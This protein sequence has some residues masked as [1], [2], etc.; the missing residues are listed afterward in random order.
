MR[1]NTPLPR[2]LREGLSEAEDL[3]EKYGRPEEALEILEKLNK[4]YPRH[5]DVLG[6][7]AN[8]YV[9]L[10]N[11]SGYLS[12]MY[13]LHKITPNRAVVKLG[14]AGAYMSTGKVALAYQTFNEYLKKW[15]HHEKVKD[16]EKAVGI[17]KESLDD[18]LSRFDLDFDK[19]LKFASQHELLQVFMELGEYRQ[20]RQIG[21][22]L[23]KER[24][25]FVPTYNNLSQI[26]WLEG[27]VDEAM[28]FSLK[29]IEFE[30][31][32]VHALSNLVRF[33]FIQGREKD[34]RLYA[35]R[36]LESK[37]EASEIWDKKI[38]ALAFIRDDEGVL[39]LFKELKE[40]KEEK[41]LSPPALHWIAVAFYATGE[42]KSARK[43]WKKILKTAP[44]FS[45]AKDNLEA[46]K[47]PETNRDCPQAFSIDMWFTRKRLDEL[48]SLVSKLAI[49]DE[50][51]DADE[52]FRE[53]IMVFFDENP[54]FIHF[55]RSALVRGDLNTKEVALEFTEMSGH[56]KM[57]ESLEDLAFGKESTDDARIRASQILSK[58]G[59]FKES[60]KAKL[61]LKGE[62]KELAMLNYEISYE[63]DDDNFFSDKVLTLLELGIEALHDGDGV[64]AEGHLRK[65][66]KKNPDS[67]TIL[68]N[69]AGALFMQDREDEAEE[70]LSRIANEFPDY[71]FGQVTAARK[72]MNAG[73]LDGAKKYID[74]LIAKPK[75][76]VTEFGALCALQI[77][78]LIEDDKPEGA[79][80][81]YEMWEQG[82]PEDPQLGDYEEKI[83]MIKLL[84]NM[85]KI[86][87]KGKKNR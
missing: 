34:A 20:G 64:E 42:I 86:I 47:M 87:N 22:R 31:D 67:P 56:P 19:G 33:M 84:K 78:F 80:T 24:P 77:D 63:S 2:R 28:G 50:N 17:L 35:D 59:F 71:F 45:L 32:N 49:D 11:K 39:N 8:V 4:R 14:L 36:L 48:S 13:R 73:D 18:I 40:T 46:L 9:D 5:E 83:E 81:W 55:V 6:M 61:W 51:E 72:A 23:L 43:Y 60:G 29:T 7:L 1:K 21:K 68:N 57:L 15:K 25:D 54:I 79:F 58:Y 66:L 70:L 41:L 30:D 52:E 76:H 53:K 69:L 3:L 12:A 82:Y 85:K 65:A 26:A 16:A 62:W 37:A 74:R 75:L 44:Y 10:G 38:E 27:N